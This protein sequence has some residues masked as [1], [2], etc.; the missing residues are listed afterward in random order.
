MPA[1]HNGVV[2]TPTPRRTFPTWVLVVVAVVVVLPLGWW[3]TRSGQDTAAAPSPVLT[4]SASSPAMTSIPP[5]APTD[6]TGTATPDSGLATISESALPVQARRTLDLI[7]AGGPY[8]YSQDGVVFQNRERLL[9]HQPS[10]YYHEYTAREPGSS[11]RGPWRLVT[12]KVGE[13]FWTSDHYSSFQQ[14][15]EGT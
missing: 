13:V 3:L 4:A 9:P 10:G 7:R 15:K 2:S 6:T 12:G 5:S 8:P 11:G 1:R 14:V